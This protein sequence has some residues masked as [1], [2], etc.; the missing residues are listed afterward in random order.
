VQVVTPSVLSTVPFH[1]FYFRCLCG[2]ESV[3]AEGFFA[4]SAQF[5]LIVKGPLVGYTQLLIADVQRH[6]T[7]PEAVFSITYAYVSSVYC[8]LAGP[9]VPANAFLRQSH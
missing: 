2:I 1:L 5:L 7:D 4:L 9:T 3:Q 8:L 6:R